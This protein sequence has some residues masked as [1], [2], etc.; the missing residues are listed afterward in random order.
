[1]DL[2]CITSTFLK[3]HVLKTNCVNSYFLECDKTDEV[4]ISN[5]FHFQMCISTSSTVA[6]L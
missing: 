2:Q 5:F 4:K 6:K 3:V 1:M